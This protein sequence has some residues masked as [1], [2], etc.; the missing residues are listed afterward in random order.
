MGFALVASVVGCPPRS[1]PS[2]DGGWSPWEKGACSVT[3]GAPGTITKTRKCNNPAPKYGGEYCHGE[4]TQ[5]DQCDYGPCSG[6]LMAI[7]GTGTNTL[8]SA[9]VVSTSCDF[10]L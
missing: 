9:E 3:C 8:R 1:P 4:D 7:G 5:I 10:P 2:V 6:S